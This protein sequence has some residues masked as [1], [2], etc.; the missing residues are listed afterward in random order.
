VADGLPI[1]AL[2]AEI[3]SW[4]IASRA[5]FHAAITKLDL[6]SD[7]VLSGETKALWTELERE[8]RLRAG[9]ARLDELTPIRDDAWFSLADRAAP[10]IHAGRVPL[11]GYLG[12][13][14]RS[15]LVDGG[16]STSVRSPQPEEEHTSAI[17]AI[18]RW[19]WL[20]IYLPPE[21]LLAALAATGGHDVRDR[22]EIMPAALGRLLLRE[23]VAQQHLHVGAGPGIERLWDALTAATEHAKR[24]D[25]EL[26]LEHFEAVLLA[27]GFARRVLAEHVERIAGGAPASFEET[28]AWF[29]RDC[30]AWCGRAP[31]DWRRDTERLLRILEQPASPVERIA[32]ITRARRRLPPARSSPPHG[33]LLRRCF[34]ALASATDARLERVFVQYIRVYAMTYRHLVQDPSSCGLDWF[35]RHFERISPMTAKVLKRQRLTQ[36]LRN[37]GLGLRLES[38]EIRTSPE[39]TWHDIG[40]E[41]RDY[42]REVAGW[43]AA[44]AEWGITFHLIKR[45]EVKVRGGRSQR[46]GDVGPGGRYGWWYREGERR[47]RAIEHLLRRRPET[48]AVIC[49]IDV[50]NVELAVP[51]WIVGPLLTRLRAASREVAREAPRRRGLHSLGEIQIVP[52]VGEDYRRLSEGLRRM[53]EALAA[54]VLGHG[55]RVGHGLALG[56]EPGRWRDDHRVVYQPLEERLFD[57]LWELKLVEDRRVISSEQ[58]IADVRAQV[59]R[60]G[61]E[62]F[63]DRDASVDRLLEGY[64]ELLDPRG[65]G[66]FGYGKLGAGPREHGTCAERWLFDRGVFLRGL[67]PISVEATEDEVAVL[68]E[69]QLELATQF[70]AASIT[71]ECNPSSNLLVGGL[72]SFLEHQVFRLHP[73]VALA[74]AAAPLP[75][76]SVSLNSDD[77]ISFA[78][79]LADEYAYT[80]HA[81]VRGETTSGDD[82]VAWLNR[83]RGMGW[84]SRITRP[85][86]RAPAVIEQLA[87]RPRR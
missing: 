57:L 29:A 7:R 2:R 52:H 72:A 70:A 66:R 30:A 48:L 85:E 21:L 67:Q 51:T 84:R 5:A 24:L 36:T 78:T 28:L 3:E 20:S 86:S 33:E 60:W 61:A 68:R 46:T 53:D 65:V 18:E 62:L 14:A 79:R 80:Y 50:A 4:P 41:V 1:N 73:P 32:W 58:R 13:L 8:L 34:A 23:P 22:V 12:R 44:P 45:H 17:D 75:S 39:P 69:A 26:P 47:I 63:S 42:A 54:G 25:G 19:R 16:G 9:R 38:L 74:A 64:R 71:I 87:R 27:A 49:G 11:H 10:G 55:G 76:V 40:R 15:V 81:L 83:I 31:Y 35:T 43:P 56:E 37:D 6:G 77:P 59:R 82:A